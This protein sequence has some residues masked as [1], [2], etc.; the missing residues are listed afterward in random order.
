MRGEQTFA[1][2]IAGGKRGS[3]PQVSSYD[4]KLISSV[5]G[6]VATFLD[7][8]RLEHRRNAMFV[9]SIRALTAMVDAKDHY[10][11]GHSER[12]ALL[13]QQLAST[14][15][16]PPET[17][18]RTHLCGLLHDVGKVGVPEAVLTKTSRLSDEEFEIIKLHPR[19]GYDMLKA[20][21]NFEDIL[22]GVLTHH[23][24]WDGRG[25]PANVAGSDIPLFGRILDLADSIDAM[26]SNRAYRS[27]LP[28]NKVIDE[29]KA[30]AG[31]QF[32]PELAPLFAAMDFT[33][34][35]D[36]LAVNADRSASMRA[37]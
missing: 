17:V 33:D 32:D 15:G 10:T 13:S 31:A 18:E 3:D 25:Y 14:M 11:L 8:A 21:P 34:F 30:C 16:L 28:R 27:A 7:N 35:D 26:S 19:Q 1:V 29:I 23:E 36:L 37:A 5:S 4:T 24:R 12:V 2:L 6:Y 20:I 22:G 9:G